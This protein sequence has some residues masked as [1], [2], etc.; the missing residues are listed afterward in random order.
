MQ[1]TTK[2]RFYGIGLLALVLLVGVLASCS[3]TPAATSTPSVETL[4]QQQFEET[5][6]AQTLEAAFQQAIAATA[7]IEATVKAQVVTIQAAT[8]QVIAAQTATQVANIQA[9]QQAQA[10]Q[11]VT[12]SAIIQ[13]TQQAAI[14]Q[15]AT[16]AMTQTAVAVATRRSEVLAGAPVI[17]NI[18]W[19]PVVQDFDGVPM[20]KVPAGCFM[21][22][23]E[24]EAHEQCF[25]EPF[26]IGETEVTNVQYAAFI[27]AG[28]YTNGAYWTDAGWAW[29]QS[30]GVTQPDC[31][32][33]SAFNQPDQPVVCVSWYEAVAY[34]AWLSATSGETF[35][36]PT[37]AEWEYAARGPDGLIYP[38]GNEWNAD[39][40]VTG[41]TSRGIAAVGSRPAGASWVGALDMSGNVWEWV[42][43]QSQPYPY[44]ATDGREDLQADGYRVVRGGSWVNPQGGARA[45][46][47]FFNLPNDRLSLNGFRVL[48]CLPIS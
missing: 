13:A 39:N 28:G 25:E 7:A 19:I 5:A 47:R 34:S 46:F 43:S 29:R 15:T 2:T 1:M 32:T 18:E 6:Q 12:Q 33:D 8:Q 22:G 9:T 14:A 35:R 30:T 4:I 36:L 37:E 3:T 38:W 44:S 23:D 24:D 48:A 11:T 42:S 27:N 31:W 20:V 21:M 45:A 10:L 40:A 16:Q 26:W 17:A 41:E